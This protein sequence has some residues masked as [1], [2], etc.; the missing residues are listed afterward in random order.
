MR[1][2]QQAHRNA[3]RKRRSTA[4]P[5]SASQSSLR[6][7]PDSPVKCNLVLMMD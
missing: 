2:V 4:R 5:D 3:N 7:N 1:P 6:L